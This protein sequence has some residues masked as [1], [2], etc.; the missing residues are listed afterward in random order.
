LQQYFSRSEKSISNAVKGVCQM[1]GKKKP[2]IN[3]DHDPL[4]RTSL[5]L[6]LVI[7][8]FVLSA[9]NPSSDVG[10][11]GRAHETAPA[12][13]E[14][15]FPPYYPTPAPEELEACLEKGG[16]WDVLG[17]MGPGCNLPTGDGGMVCQDSEECESLC[18]ADTEEVM[19]EEAGVL[20][21]DPERI[22]QLNAQEDQIGGACSSWQRNFGCRVVV[23]DGKYQEICI[24]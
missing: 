10:T 21:P 8:I 6:L 2:Q 22:K 13:I 24:D 3:V 12:E 19:K 18:L 14:P 7:V 11:L 9:C 17:K 23:E 16:K 15:S 1:R 20:V 4:S 5:C